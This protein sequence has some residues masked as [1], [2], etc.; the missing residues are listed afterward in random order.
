VKRALLLPVL[1]LAAMA[2][3]ASA[4]FEGVADFKITTGGPQGKSTPG[5][6]KIFIAPGGYRMEFEMSGRSKDGKEPAREGAAPIAMVMLGKASDPG[7]LY[8][9]NDQRKTY[10]VLDGKKAAAQAPRD[11]FTVQKLGRDTV[12]GLSCQIAVLTSSRGSEIE[13]CMASEPVIASDWLHGLNRSQADP[14]SWFAA[15]GAEGIQGFPVRWAIRKKGSTEIL[16][17]MEITRLEKKSLPASLFDVPAGYTRSGAPAG[18]LTPEQE[19]AM[20]DARAQMGD[21]LEKM[22]PEQR[23]AYE[24]A[25]RRYVQLPPTPVPTPKP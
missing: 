22:T 2:A 18:A 6:G 7:K 5:A 11:T 13:I 8:L 4:P 20:A 17:S 12:A 16:A 1:L 19:K 9:V 14:D 3:S 24:D 23:K 25:M 15:L 21:A 10:V